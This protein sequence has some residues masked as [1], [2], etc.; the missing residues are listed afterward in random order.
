MGTDTLKF[1]LV[2]RLGYWPKH[3]TKDTLVYRLWFDSDLFHSQCVTLWMNAQGCVWYIWDCQIRVISLLCIM[4]KFSLQSF[5]HSILLP[6]LSLPCRMYRC[7]NRPRRA[8]TGTLQKIDH[9]YL[10]TLVDVRCPNAVH[11]EMSK[12]SSEYLPQIPGVFYRPRYVP[13]FSWK[14]SEWHDLLLRIVVPLVS[15]GSLC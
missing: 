1:L 5:L 13:G 15:I 12:Q 3:L 10:H 6:W 14:C 2:P 8:L 9:L 7:K 11:T 4:P